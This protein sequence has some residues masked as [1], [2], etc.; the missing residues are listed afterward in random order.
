MDF[1][2]ALY[3]SA[4]SRSSS[5]KICLC[6]KHWLNWLSGKC[7]VKYI[8]MTLSASTTSAPPIGY[9]CMQMLLIFERRRQPFPPCEPFFFCLSIKP[10]WGPFWSAAPWNCSIF[11]CCLVRVK[12]FTKCQTCRWSGWR[13]K[14][15]V[16]S[17][18][19]CFLVTNSNFETIMREIMTGWIWR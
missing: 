15:E 2:L 13:R 11:V 4:L 1:P 19:K 16:R 6:N 8:V 12:H 3:R 17:V 7:I 5:L 14:K 9:G 10:F 18:K